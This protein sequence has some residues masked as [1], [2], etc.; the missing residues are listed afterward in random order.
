MRP[1][2]SRPGGRCANG[3]WFPDLD[4]DRRRVRLAVRTERDFHRRS[5]APVAGRAATRRDADTTDAWSNPCVAHGQERDYWCTRP[6]SEFG[7]VG[8]DP[9]LGPGAKRVQRGLAQH[10]SE[11]SVRSFARASGSVKTDAARECV[12]SRGVD[13]KCRDNA[14]DRVVIPRPRQQRRHRI[15]TEATA[16]K[17]WCDRAMDSHGTGP[18]TACGQETRQTDHAGNRPVDDR[19][20][21]PVPAMRMGAKQLKIARRCAEELAA[22]WSDPDSRIAGFRCSQ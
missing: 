22:I 17:R 5:M 21:R 1:M 4:R 9:A 10:Q 14:R 11:G 2:Q 16:S 3:R 18:F 8:N 13:R 7:H 15:A 6:R 19:P 12:R 20:H